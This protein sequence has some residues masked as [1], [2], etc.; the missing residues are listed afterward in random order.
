MTAK[1]T[2]DFAFLDGP[3]F[4]G[5]V[6]RCGSKKCG[7]VINR[8]S[9]DIFIVCLAGKNGLR[10]LRTGFGRGYFGDLPFLYGSILRACQKKWRGVAKG[11]VVGG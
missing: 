3:D 1:H 2:L 4:D 10:R 6:L 11:I 9:I 5:T 7:I 8:N